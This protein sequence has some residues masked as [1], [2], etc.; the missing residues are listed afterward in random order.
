M[1]TD[2]LKE[3]LRGQ[4]KYSWK[5][6]RWKWESLRGRGMVMAVYV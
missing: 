3:N 1:V 4:R 2:E 6:V 5:G